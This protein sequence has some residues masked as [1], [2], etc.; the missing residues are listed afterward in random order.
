MNMKKTLVAMLLAVICL[1]SF[2]QDRTVTG[3]VTDAK[4]GSPLVAASVAVKGTKKGVS[5]SSDGTF[6]LKVSATENTVVVS[7]L[8]YASKEVS[9]A[10]QNNIN[11][12]LTQNSEQLGDVVVIGYGSVRKKDLTGSVTNVS[13]KDFVKGQLTSPEQ[14]IAGKVAG[15]QITSNGGAPGAGSTIPIRGSAP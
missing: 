12:S 2:A 7:F 15:V 10:G 6:S 9:I 5:T 8:N 4:D 13:A 11:V 1:P 3:K 14:L